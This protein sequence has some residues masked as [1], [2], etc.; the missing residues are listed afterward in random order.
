MS[1]VS[2][3]FPTLAFLSSSASTDDSLASKTLSI[4]IYRPLFFLG[5]CSM[6]KCCLGFFLNNLFLLEK[7]IKNID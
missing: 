5:T 1:L 2:M 6:V 4:Q 7:K 3:F